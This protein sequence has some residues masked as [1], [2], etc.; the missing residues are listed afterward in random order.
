[1]N[2]P[3]VPYL[4]S[5]VHIQQRYRDTALLIFQK[6]QKEKRSNYSQ[7]SNKPFSSTSDYITVDH[8]GN[9]GVVAKKANATSNRNIAVKQ[10]KII[11]KTCT[12]V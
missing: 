1:M 7:S 4:E 12:I 10:D 8:Y 6:I 11:S 5:T 9:S 2:E 3:P